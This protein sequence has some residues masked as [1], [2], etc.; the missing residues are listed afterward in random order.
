MGKGDK[1]RKNR[2][3]SMGSDQERKEK[4]SRDRWEHKDEGVGDLF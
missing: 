4:K 2:R 3:A 1:K